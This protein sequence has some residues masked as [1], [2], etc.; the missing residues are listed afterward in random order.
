MITPPQPAHMAYISS[1]LKGAAAEMSPHDAHVARD[2]FEHWRSECTRVANEAPVRVAYTIHEIIDERVER[3]RTSKHGREIT[4]RKGCAA[5]CHLH[6]DIF[7]HEAEMLLLAMSTD[8]I[9][10]DRA[11]LERQATKDDE[12]WHELAPE[13]QRCVFL[14]E[15]RTCRVYE[16]RPGSCRKYHVLSDPDLCDAVKHPRAKVGIMFDTEGEIV[17]SAAM[18]VYGGGTMA[19]VLLQHLPTPEADP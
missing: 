1:T 4:C 8:G 7:H 18:T 10:I 5:C 14:G 6:V 2:C 12:T 3:L 19:A 16:H 9:E 15:D 17:H 11:R 13:D